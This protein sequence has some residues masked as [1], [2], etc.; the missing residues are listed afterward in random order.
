M[1]AKCK[2]KPRPPVRFRCWAVMWTR[3]GGIKECE[4]YGPANHREA[5][6]EVAWQQ[7]RDI[8][9]RIVRGHFVE[10]RK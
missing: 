7:T 1:K 10:D 6:G 5:A 8:D 2:A 4:V 9:A 3:P